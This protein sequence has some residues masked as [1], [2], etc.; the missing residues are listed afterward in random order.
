MN[1]GALIYVSGE[2]P[3]IWSASD[4]VYFRKQVD[5][6]D[7]VRIMPTRANAFQVHCLCLD[8]L[9]KGM[10]EI[11]LAT[12]AFKKNGKL[13]LNKQCCRIPLVVIN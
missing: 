5:Y 11:V 8:M 10:T 13:E 3:R 2:A 4:D 7:M 6:F 1:T 9:S 12:A